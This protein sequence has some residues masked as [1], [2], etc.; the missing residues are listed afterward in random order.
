M[1]QEPP[2][3]CTRLQTES[4][5]QESE[6]DYEE[7]SLGA[8]ILLEPTVV[9]AAGTSNVTAKALQQRAVTYAKALK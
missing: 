6:A 5:R 4:P 8:R 2:S 7:I 9:G 1:G 3:P